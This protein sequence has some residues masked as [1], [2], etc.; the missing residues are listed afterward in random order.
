[1]TLPHSC[2]RKHSST[3]KRDLQHVSRASEA[4]EVCVAPTAPTSLEMHAQILQWPSSNTTPLTHAH[5]CKTT[6]WKG[7]AKWT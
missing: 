3:S 7:T 1:M 5:H 2:A 4:Q 6:M